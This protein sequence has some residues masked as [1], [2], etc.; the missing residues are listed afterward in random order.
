MAKKKKVVSLPLK[1]IAL[2][3]QGFHL[4]LK[5]KINNKV[6]RLI[7]DTGASKTVFDRDK[8]KKYVS[9]H[10]FEK[11][12]HLSTGLG[13]DSMESH[14]VTVKKIVLGTIAIPDFNLVLLD[15]NHIS[16]SYELMGLPSIDGVL[17]GDILRS[18]GAVIDYGK[19]E[20]TLKI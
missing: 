9:N 8:I 12:E 11:N 15:L 13:T 5:A 1:L 20:L 6:A 3:Q 2:E 7:L 4:M 19:L 17:G 18:C 16:R 14:S 10:A